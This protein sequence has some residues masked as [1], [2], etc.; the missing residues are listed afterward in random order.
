MGFGSRTPA[1]ERMDRIRA[2]IVGFGNV[3]RALGNLLLHDRGHAI[4]LNVV[5]PSPSIAGPLL[6]IGHAA[7]FCPW[8]ERSLNDLGLL[9]E[10]DIIFLAAGMRNAAG[11]SRLDVAGDNIR[12]VREIFSPL[13]LRRDPWIVVISNPV[14]VITYHVGEMR[15]VDPRRVIGTGTLLDSMR[16][17]YHLAEELSVPLREVHAWVIGEHGESQVPVFSQSRVRDRPAVDSAPPTLLARC[18]MLA[19]TAARRIRQDQPGTW[20]GVSTCAY[21]I[22]RALRG[23]VRLRRPVSVRPRGAWA[24]R[25]GT[26]QLAFGLPAEVHRGGHELIEPFDLS[27]SEMDAVIRS[28]RVI[29]EH[30]G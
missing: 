25:L 11:G 20:W 1:S 21:H 24:R 23:E 16:L 6:D 10:S 9:A 17:E 7:T 5:D 28:A 29:R 15:G 4:H 27:R 22:F 30:L 13:D 12:L 8:H 14:D 18:A 3:G 2:S 19:R 26:D